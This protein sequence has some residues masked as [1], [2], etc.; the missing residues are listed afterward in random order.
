MS[1]ISPPSDIPNLRK[2]VPN[3][4][5]DEMFLK[6]SEFLH[7]LDLYS[8]TV[9]ENLSKYCAEQ[10]GLSVED[11]LILKLLSVLGDRYLSKVINDSRD[12]KQL[13]LMNS[14]NDNK[15][16]LLEELDDIDLTIAFSNEN[17]HWESNDAKKATAKNVSPKP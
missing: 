2:D 14:K 5:K 7:D 3:D 10:S 13:R 17:I 1:K 11:P 9:P 6:Y 16:A 8:P 4:R 12:M 15:A